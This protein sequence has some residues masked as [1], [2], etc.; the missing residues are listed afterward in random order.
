MSSDEHLGPVIALGDIAHADLLIGRV[1][2]VG[3]VAAGVHPAVDDGLGRGVALGDVFSRGAVGKPEGGDHLEGGAVCRAGVGKVA[4]VQHILRLIAGDPGQ[5]PVGGQG[6]QT[7]L[8]ADLV[9]QADHLRLIAGNSVVQ[10]GDLEHLARI[11]QVGIADLGIC[12]DDLAGANLILDRQLPHGVA[13]DDGMGEGGG[14]RGD[15]EQTSRQ[16]GGGKQHMHFFHNNTSQ[17]QCFGLGQ[18]KL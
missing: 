6:L 5:L 10:L 9:D 3:A 2:N 18:N 14:A 4:V 7:V 15:G 16:D 17:K 11:D 8:L 12:L 1:Q 13:G